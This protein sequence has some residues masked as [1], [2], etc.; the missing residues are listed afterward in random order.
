[1]EIH[2]NNY[3]AYFLDYLE[4]RLSEQEIALL[5]A[6]LEKNPDLEDELYQFENITLKESDINLKNKGV[7]FK[8]TDDYP[9]VNEQN[10]PEFCVAH[11]ENQ[12]GQRGEQMLKVYLE[13]NPSLIKEYNLYSKVYLEVDP[14]Q[15]MPGKNHLKH[16]TFSPARRWLLTASAVAAILIFALLLL[17]LRNKTIT[18]QPETAAVNALNQAQTPATSPVVAQAPTT[19]N[20]N[21]VRAKTPRKKLLIASESVDS[22]KVSL[23]K[24]VREDILLAAIAPVEL[25]SLET[26]AGNVN[27]LPARLMLLQKP[28]NGGRDNH[29]YEP[30]FDYALAEVKNKVQETIPTRKE[31]GK[32]SWWGIAEYGVKGFNQIT[33]SNLRLER[34]TDNNGKEI[35]ALGAGKLEITAPLR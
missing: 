10:F 5:L 24:E 1:M 33:G 27:L 12:L 22:M 6:F 35:L 19:K 17:P 13:S 30:L 18:L 9:L 21:T 31:D 16:V 15:R 34:R 29:E 32:L 25:H 4:G 3:E 11:F 14:S 8:S 20:E 7:M 23:V 26:G 2:R 28:G